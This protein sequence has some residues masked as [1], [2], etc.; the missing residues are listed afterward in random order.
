MIGKAM[1]RS[2]WGRLDDDEEQQCNE[3]MGDNC[4]MSHTAILTMNLAHQIQCEQ[5]NRREEGGN[6][7]G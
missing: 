3:K 1:R 2:G 7:M 4:Q 6:R 5:G